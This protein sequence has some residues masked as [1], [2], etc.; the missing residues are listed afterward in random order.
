[1]S[2][3][4][5]G[6]LW[7]FGAAASIAAF[8]VPWKLASQHGGTASNA[9]LLLAVAAA[10]NTLLTLAQRRAFPRF[11]RADVVIATALACVTLAG[12]LAS[13]EAIRSLSPALLTVTQRSEIILVALMAWPIVGERVDARFWL[14]A[15]IAAAGLFVLHDPFEA[16]DA[17]AVGVAWGL[18]SADC[19]AALAVL[20]RRFIHRIDVVSVNAQRLWLSVVTWFGFNDATASLAEITPVQVGYASLAAFFG[21]FA[22]RLC[23]MMS[24]HHLEAR[25]TTLVTLAAPPLTLGLAY[26]VLGDLPGLRDGIGGTLILCGVAVPILWRRPAAG[27]R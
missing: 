19:F 21:P 3:H 6:L 12:N 27:G 11:T 13:A 25:I 10:L 17:K 24:A 18:A 26:V 14:G 8:T 1:M 9:L 23:M 22:G 7:A 4:R 20:T 5:R 2:E 16:P 15:A